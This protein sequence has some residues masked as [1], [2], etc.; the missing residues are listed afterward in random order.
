M[1]NHTQIFLKL[2]ASIS[3]SL[4]V[5]TIL[6]AMTQDLVE[7][8]DLKAASVRLL[9]EDKRTLKSVASFGLSEKYLNKGPIHGG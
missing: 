6:Q 7:S 2:A 3:Q 8:L 4:D 5:K 9:D 1:R